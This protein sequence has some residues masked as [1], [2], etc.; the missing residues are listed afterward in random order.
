[1]KLR[2]AARSTETPTIAGVA[3]FEEAL[4]GSVFERLAR[5]VRSIGRERI[6]RNYTTTFWMPVGIEPRNVAEEAALLLQ[7]LAAPGPTCVGIEWWLGRL[8]YGQ[9][10]RLHFDRDMTLRKQTGQFVHPLRASALYL[11]DFPSSPTVILDQVPSPDGKSR[12]PA[13]GATRNLIEP[14]PNR[15]SVFPG[16]LRHGVIP[17]VETDEETDGELRLSLL[18]NFWDHRPLPPLGFEYDGSIYPAL[19]EV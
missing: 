12:I 8:R 7:D 10:L 6:K 16:N 15:Y 5:A 4:P 19:S 3:V 13:R 2:L 1:M 11:N 17:D 18:V 14:A 9:K